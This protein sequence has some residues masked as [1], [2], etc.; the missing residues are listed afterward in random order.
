[1]ERVNRLRELAASGVVG[2]LASVHYS[3]MG[4]FLPEA[5][6]PHAKH[7][8]GLLKNDKVDAAELSREEAGVALY[9]L[10][11]RQK[12]SP[13]SDLAVLRGDDVQWADPPS[14]EKSFYHLDDGFLHIKRK[15]GIEKGFSRG[16]EIDV[17]DIEVQE[18]RSRVC[19]RAPDIDVTL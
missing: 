4:A 5:A 11:L 16:V 15:P 3:F 18:K 2:S 6:A 8:A 19:E 14:E 1:M 12:S 17:F 7:L 9:Q 10:E 13:E